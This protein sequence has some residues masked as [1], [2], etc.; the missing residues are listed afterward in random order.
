MVKTNHKIAGKIV[1]AASFNTISPFVV[2]KGRSLSEKTDGDVMTDETGKPYL[3]A[4]GFA[5]KLKAFIK[6]N[7]APCK[8]DLSEYFWGTE[9]ADGTDDKQE[10]QSH[11]NLENILTFDEFSKSKIRIRDGV[12]I[13]YETGIAKAGAKYDY[14]VVEPGLS[15]FLRAEIT[16]RADVDFEEISKSIS[17]FCAALK[18]DDF[19]IG[20]LTNH[21]FGRIANVDFNAWHFNLKE[22]VHSNYWFNYLTKLH[23]H[24]IISEQYFKV[25]PEGIEPMVINS[26]EIADQ[27][28]FSITASFNLKNAMIIGT[29]GTQKDDS[30]KK[31]LQCNGHDVITGKSIRGALRNRAERVL[32][33]LSADKELVCTLFGNVNEDDESRTKKGKLRIEETVLEKSK[34]FVQ[35]RTR[36]DRFTGGVRS[37][38]LFNSEPIETGEHIKL[39][40]TI[41]KKAEPA[42]KGLL[43]LLLKD[44]WTADLA[45]GGEKNIGRGILQGLTA[46]IKD[47]GTETSINENGISVEE[48]NRFNDYAKAIIK[49]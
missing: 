3:P 46:T 16:I 7:L 17:Q 5:G 48:I 29:Y 31:H 22:K 43:L 15:F 39:Q 34:S 12:K 6:A 11:L 19:S 21:G 36:I 4:S 38:A 44:L 26:L 8:N 41:S 33:T 23:S 32:E 13:D 30:D 20:A 40:F 47:N 27:D 37:G 24:G 45:I 25:F 2:G 10:Y 28:A 9:K 14:Q 35:N 49:N 42:E 18:H 1:I